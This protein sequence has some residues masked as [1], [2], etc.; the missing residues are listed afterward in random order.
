MLYKSIYAIE[1]A[2][3]AIELAAEMD[4][5][6]Q[7]PIMIY[8]VDDIYD[9]VTAMGLYDIINFYKS[10]L[11][12]SIFYPAGNSQFALLAAAAVDP[13]KRFIAEHAIFT[14]MIFGG[15]RQGTYKDIVVAEDELRVTKELCVNIFNT[16]NIPGADDIADK[17][18]VLI[19]PLMGDTFQIAK[20]GFDE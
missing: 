3:L 14:P 10:S 11:D 5:E 18:K 1:P 19:P 9:G 7:T 20:G 12:I 17:P 4:S 15:G 16:L 2:R 8:I 6:T 13:D